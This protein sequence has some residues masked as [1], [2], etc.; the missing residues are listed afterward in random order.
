MQAY[1]SVELKVTVTQ[2]VITLR[3]LPLATLPRTHK[4]KARTVTQLEVP[5][6][7]YNLLRCY[8]AYND[9]DL[10]TLRDSISV[11]SSKCQAVQ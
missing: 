7:T 4:T 11:P 1:F 3:S 10:T 9:K 2:Y 6:R 5:L 8:A